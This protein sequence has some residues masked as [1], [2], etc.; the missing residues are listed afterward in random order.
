MSKIAL[1]TG[2]SS[3]IGWASAVLLAEEGYDLI[4]CGRRE[5]RLKSLGEKLPTKT[6]CLVFD[7]SDRGGEIGRAHV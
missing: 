6:F 5:D 7:V 1:V 2:A 4:L 3:G